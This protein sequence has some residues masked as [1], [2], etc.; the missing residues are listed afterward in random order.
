[1]AEN[2][3]D[4]RLF[5]FNLIPPKSKEEVRT[6]RERDNS[7]FYSVLLIIFISLIY[8]GLLLFDSGVVTPRLNGLD[9]DLLQQ[10]LQITTYNPV[11]QANGELF[12]KSQII[13]PLL[14]LDIGTIELLETSDAI[15]QNVPNAEIISYEREPDGTF[16]ITVILDNIE[17][18]TLLITN[19]QN[20]T[21]VENAFMRQVR[22]DDDNNR[23]RSVLAFLIVSD[24]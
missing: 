15:I 22:V 12:V 5:D 20:Q 16:V 3:Y 24:Q 1:M 4:K 19:A 6:L 13:A 11:K 2:K 14:E 17:D 8:F 21:N 18:S 9:D 23:I 10:D 7:I